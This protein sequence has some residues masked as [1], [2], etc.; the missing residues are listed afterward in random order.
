MTFQRLAYQ[1]SIPQLVPK[2]YLGHANGI[3]QLAIGTAQFLVPLIAVGMLAAIGLEG[4][5][6]IQVAAYVFAVVV[7]LFV[8]FPTTLGLR[9]RE[10]I[11]AEIVNGFRFS[12]GHPGFRAMLFFFAG[13]NLFLAPMFVMISP[14][15]LS[16]ASLQA[17]G[18]VAVAAGAG[19]IIGGVVMSLWGGPTRRRLRGV[20]AATHADGGRGPADRA[21]AQPLA[22]RRR[23]LRHVLRAG[24]DQR[25]RS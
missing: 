23:R 20:I 5:L 4:I 9:R 10:P 22:D 13:V 16:F 11:S 14:L 7:V 25:H 8:K 1:A 17:A 3:V 2:R 21:A 12:L 15:V 24:P 6:T 18:A 19:A